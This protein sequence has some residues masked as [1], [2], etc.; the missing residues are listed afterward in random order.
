MCG[1][2]DVSSRRIIDEK[3]EKYLLALHRGFYLK[4]DIAKGSKV[5]LDDLYL[6]IPFQKDIGHMSSRN[7][8]N[9]E[10]VTNKN[11]KKD[12][13]LTIDDVE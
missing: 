5:T 11:L 10:Y 6:A 7:F 2:T 4:K 9:T 13:P 8:I 12:A 1:S 3:E